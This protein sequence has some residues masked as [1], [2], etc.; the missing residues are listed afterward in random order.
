MFPKEKRKHPVFVTNPETIL[1]E[2]FA[3][4][5]FLENQ[6]RAVLQ[7]IKTDGLTFLDDHRDTDQDTDLDAI[8]ITYDYINDRYVY[9][10]DSSWIFP[11]VMNYNGQCKNPLYVGK[12][13]KKLHVTRSSKGR[14]ITYRDIRLSEK[15]RVYDEDNTKDRGMI[16]QNFG[17][18]P[19]RPE[20]QGYELNLIIPANEIVELFEKCLPV[21]Q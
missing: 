9:E 12:E 19:Y 21:L 1:R 2:A 18:N 7:A 4:S 14:M 15:L 8:G 5:K 16:V 13:D 20:I 3:A 11:Y 6:A 17:I 10:D